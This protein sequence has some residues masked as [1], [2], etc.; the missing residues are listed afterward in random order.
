MK[1]IRNGP[2]PLKV[3]MDPTRTDRWSV[4]PLVLGLILLAA[5]SAGTHELLTSGRDDDWLILLRTDVQLLLGL[6]LLCGLKPRWVRASLVLT[7]VGIL[8]L[9][10]WRGR[11]S[12]HF[13]SPHL[14]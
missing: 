13:R 2:S 10:L 6:W 8:A 7:A 14:V 1:V 3:A 11:A 9:E 5:G 12:R 4:V